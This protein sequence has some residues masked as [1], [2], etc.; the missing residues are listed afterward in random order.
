MSKP[1]DA[2]GR[3]LTVDEVAARLHLAAKTIRGMLRNGH[4]HGVKSSPGRTGVWRVTEDEVVR[5]QTQGSVR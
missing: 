1:G 5:W 3:L 2:A 4:L